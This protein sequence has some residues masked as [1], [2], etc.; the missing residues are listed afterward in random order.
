LWRAPVRSC[1]PRRA[2][3][4]NRG[5]LAWLAILNVALGLF[6]LVPVFPLH[7]PVAS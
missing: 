3:P 6:N 4:A 5:V 7:R 2:S 1:R